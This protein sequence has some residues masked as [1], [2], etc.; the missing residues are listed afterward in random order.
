M[1]C[2]LA[3]WVCSVLAGVV[4]LADWPGWRG[5]LRNGLSDSPAPIR[6]ASGSPSIVWKRLLPGRGMSSPVISQKK[7]VLTAVIPAR[8]HVDEWLLI[9]GGLSIFTLF[10]YRPSTDSPT[11]VSRFFPAIFGGIAAFLLVG[12][13]ALITPHWVPRQFLSVPIRYLAAIIPAVLA[14]RT[15]TIMLLSGACQK[16]AQQTLRTYVIVTFLVICF[17]V[18]LLGDSYWQN[19]SPESSSCAEG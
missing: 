6:W 9:V 10:L 15:M 4:L 17:T 19:T 2:V 14:L 1:R 7:I 12:D 8:R 16:R 5:P 13:F 11:V 3:Y 18:G